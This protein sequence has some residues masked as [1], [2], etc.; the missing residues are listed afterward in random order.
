VDSN[1]ALQQYIDIPNTADKNPL[2]FSVSLWVKADTTM[3][4]TN[5]NLFNKYRPALW[6]G[7]QLIFGKDLAAKKYYVIPWYLNS[8]QNR[9][10]GDYGEPPFNT[11]V[12]GDKWNHFVFTVDETEGIMYL[13]NVKVGTH[14][15][16]GTAKPSSN[17]LN[18][19][20]GG[21]YV[22]WFKGSIDELRV[23]NRALK[24]FEVQY[25]FE[26]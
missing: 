22:D 4:S 18:W 3:N 13:N 11:E 5:G 21:K 15:W 24:D 16:T 17:G 20:I 7:F 8:G 1:R 2:P 25:L 12:P 23:Y 14:P 19:K 10:I 6:N 26:H 9:L